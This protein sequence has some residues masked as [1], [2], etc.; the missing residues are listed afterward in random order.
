MGRQRLETTRGRVK[1][2]KPVNLG[3]K[4]EA[5]IEQFESR[6]ERLSTFYTEMTTKYFTNVPQ[7]TLNVKNVPNNIYYHSLPKNDIILGMSFFF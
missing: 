2:E 1:K 3:R 4:G 6:L 5:T 7:S